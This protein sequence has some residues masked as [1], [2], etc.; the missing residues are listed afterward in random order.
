MK[1]A[2]NIKLSTFSYEEDDADQIRQGLLDL[3]PFDLEQEKLEL[4]KTNVQGF[5]EKCIIIFELFMKKERHTNKF[6]N[7]IKEQLTTD[8]RNL[9]L[10]QQESRLD[11]KLDFFLRIDKPRF[12]KDGVVQLTEQGNC[13]HIRISIAAYPAHREQALEVVQE[14]LGGV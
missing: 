11:E 5:K 10:R 3:V 2:H 13:Y 4:K 9:L 14:W 8:Q 12:L 7:H 6:L 1:I